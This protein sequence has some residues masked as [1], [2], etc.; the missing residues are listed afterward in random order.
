MSQG[1]KTFKI[2]I[3]GVVQG[4]GFRRFVFEKAIGLNLNGFVKNLK[5]G[6]VLVVV[7]GEEEKV[8]E[9]Y[10]A[11]RTGPPLAVVDKITME[12]TK[13]KINKKGFSIL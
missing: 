11:C 6:K 4:V 7:E 5:N 12:E 3:S 10:E 9:L 8:K 1:N 2:E 13:I